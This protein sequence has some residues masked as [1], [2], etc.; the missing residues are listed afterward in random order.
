M[1]TSDNTAG[2]V[3][4][5]IEHREPAGSVLKSAADEPI[6]DRC[7]SAGAWETAPSKGRTKGTL[8][9]QERAG[10]PY[11][12]VDDHKQFPVVL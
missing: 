2:E 10:K 7:V 12:D 4:T 9:T 11:P 5:T 3:R 1:W 8:H 6:S